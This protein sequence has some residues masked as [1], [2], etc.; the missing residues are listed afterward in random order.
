LR[1]KTPLGFTIHTTEINALWVNQ[2]QA[3]NRLVVI[4]KRF[5]NNFLQAIFYSWT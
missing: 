2:Y 5:Y 3:F 4:I 1:T